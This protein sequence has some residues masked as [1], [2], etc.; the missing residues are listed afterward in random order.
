MNGANGYD[1]YS[2]T[3]TVTEIDG[4]HRVT[5]TDKN[6]NK[7]FDV[8]N[9]TGSSGTDGQDG[10]SPTVAITDITGGHRV[11]ITDKNGDK[12]FDV[13][14]GAKGDKGDAFTYADFTTEQLASL[15][16]A[17]GDPGNN[18]YTPVR[19]TDYWTETDINTIKGYVDEAI[20][21]GAW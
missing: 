12:T 4:G 10:Y 16:G 19:G 15:K 11:T 2:P 14:D 20:L 13:M 18:G 6:G 5:I 21:G 9:G 3:V 17:Q 7:T 8:M 1:G